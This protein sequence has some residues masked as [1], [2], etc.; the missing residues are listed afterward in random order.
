MCRRDITGGKMMSE[1]QKGTDIE[2]ENLGLDPELFAMILEYYQV[3]HFGHFTGV[4]IVGLGLG[5]VVT[6][7]VVEEHNTNAYSILH[8]GA[9]ATMADISMAIACI[10]TGIMP[11]TGSMN[12]SFLSTGKAGNKITAVGQVTKPGKTA[13]FTETTVEDEMGRIIAKG[14]G[15]FFTRKT[16]A[17]HVGKLKKMVTIQE[18]GDRRQE[19][20]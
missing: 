17:E 14:T 7:L 3:N 13:Y 9:V 20:E 11:I 12:I 5:K 15:T 16:F 6:Q 8:G 18:S 2:T 1:I 19:S 10:T 4:K